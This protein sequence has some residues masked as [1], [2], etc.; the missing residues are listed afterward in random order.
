MFKLNYAGIAAAFIAASTLS[1]CGGGDNNAPSDNPH[2]TTF[3]SVPNVT[4]STSFSNDG[5][6]VYQGR[7]YL[8]DRN[9]KAVDVYDVKTHALVG[10]IKGTGASAF[11]GAGAS[12]DSSGPNSVSPVTG[13]NKMYA[14]DVDSVKIID[15]GSN[16]VTGV[17][18]I[19]APGTTAGTGHRADASCYDADDHLLMVNNAA[20][21]FSTW[22]NTD[23][24]SVVAQYAY[25]DNTTGLEGC[26]Y[27]HSTRTFYT[28]NDGT[29]TNPN[30]ELNRI[31]ASAVLNNGTNPISLAAGDRFTLGQ[32]GPGGIDLGPGTDLIVA[33]DMSG[34]NGA[35]LITQILN[36]TNG[37]I[38]ATVPFGGADLLSYDSVSNRY[39]LGARNW[40]TGGVA[41]KS[42]P[43]NPV[44]GIID[45]A[46]H[47]LLFQVAA[48]KGA[49]VAVVDPATQ[50]VFVPAS[51]GSAFTDPGIGVYSTH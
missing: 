2:L 40:Q 47:A 1:A 31:T 44:L 6:V 35:K 28:A 41:N 11:T 10:L 9:N 33:C 3:M 15:T 46:T 37:Q 27:D 45:G 26:V 8:T 21:S 43:F 42:L 51:A 4:G 13:T 34:T 5:G 32:C 22:I 17:I 25:P 38:V 36:R 16:T 24:D 48:G 50:Q 49:H 30:G 39:Y 23:N 18:P 19:N 29:D 12:T 7:F 14:T 20:D